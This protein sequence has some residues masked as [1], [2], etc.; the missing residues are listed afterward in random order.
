MLI[1]SP[2]PLCSASAV[3]DRGAGPAVVPRMQHRLT[4]Q[5]KVPIQCAPFGIVSWLRRIQTE[6]VRTGCHLRFRW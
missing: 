1:N 6:R 4:G 5:V 2:N 3:D